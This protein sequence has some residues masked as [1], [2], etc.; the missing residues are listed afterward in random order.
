MTRSSIRDRLTLAR[1]R[2]LALGPVELGRAARWRSIRARTS[3]SSP[4]GRHRSAGRSHRLDRLRRPAARLGKVPLPRL[5]ALGLAVV[6]DLRLPTGDGS[7]FLSDGLRRRP[8][9]PGPGARSDGS[10]ST[11]RSATCS[12]RAA[13]IAQLVAGDGFTYGLAASTRLAAHRA[14]DL[15]RH[16]RFVGPATARAGPRQRPRP[17][18]P[19]LP[20]RRAGARLGGTSRSMWAPAP[21]SPGWAT[22]VTAVSRSASSPA[23]AGS[24]LVPAAAEAASGTPGDRDGDGVPD[25]QDRC[26]DQPGPAELE[27]CPDR[28]GD[29]IPDLDDK[30]PDQPGSA[31]TTAVPPPEEQPLVQ[32]ES[33]RCS[34][35]TPSPST[36]GA[37]RCGRSRP[38]LDRSRAR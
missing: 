27:G 12:A 25:A 11:P 31:S 21:G 26:P 1:P 33:T 9:A 28:D 8:P 15:A 7:A 32:M 10:G 3:R 16:R 29:G 19:L 36:P 22:P 6:L 17:R 24:R 4:S 2:Q 20:R 5:L 35:G 18:P 30:C 38:I 34:C 14:P 13:S 23:C 37:I